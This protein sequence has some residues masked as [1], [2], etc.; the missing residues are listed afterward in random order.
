VRARSAL[1]AAAVLLAGVLPLAADLGA[2]PPLPIRNEPYNGKFT[3][4]RVSFRPAVWGPGNYEWG[5]DLGWNHDFP[6]AD[7]HFAKILDEL[8]TIDP[9]QDAVIYGF[10]DPELFKYPFAYVSEPGRWAA[11]EKEIVALRAYLQ[12]GG[13][14][15]FDDFLARD[16]ANLE[17]IM[18]QVLPEARFLEVPLD[19]PIWDSF[20]KIADPPRV[21][22]YPQLS[23]GIPSRYF[24]IFEDNDPHKRLL[25]IADYNNDISEYWEWSDTGLLPIDLSNE[26]YKVGVNYVVYAMTH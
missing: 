26:A 18:R 19:H 13:F 5:L 6:K 1:P 23:R 7:S 2:P 24:G 17:G 10:D 12:K 11:N 9:N 8:T 3:F 20:F 15:M 25:V 22:P 4:A 14:V 16:M 21:H